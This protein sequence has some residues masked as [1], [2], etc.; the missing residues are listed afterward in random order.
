MISLPRVGS[1]RREKIV[2][3][4]F[5]LDASAVLALLQGEPGAQATADA[6]AAG[7]DLTSV[8]YLEVLT[9]SV[10][11]GA[12]LAAVRNVVRRLGLSIVDVDMVLAERAAALREAT[13][14]EGL[15][16]GDRICLAHAQGKGSTAVTA[17]RSWTR[18]RTDIDIMLIR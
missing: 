18:T 11:R 16:M 13:R 6:A 3:N 7:A 10:D 17:D 5:V 15:S 14:A 8:N 12:D 9:R 1:R 4:R 2:A